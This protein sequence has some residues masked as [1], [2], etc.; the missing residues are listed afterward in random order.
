MNK[1]GQQNLILVIIVCLVFLCLW[2]DYVG[3]GI[4]ILVA[5]LVIRHFTKN[6]DEETIEKDSEAGETPKESPE[7]KPEKW[8]AI[9]SSSQPMLAEIIVGNLENEGIEAVLIN[10]KSTPYNMFGDTEVNVRETDALRAKEIIKK[11]NPGGV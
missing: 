6:K 2:A 8:V 3:L 4:F 5:Y 11:E 10:K 7:D 9:Y 1:V